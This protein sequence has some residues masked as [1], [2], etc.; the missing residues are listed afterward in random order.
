MARPERRHGEGGWRAPLL[1]PQAIPCPRARGEARGKGRRVGEGKEEPFTGHHRTDLTL[2]GLDSGDAPNPKPFWGIRA[3]G[4]GGPRYLPLLP[5]AGREGEGCE[6]GTPEVV[7]FG[8]RSLRA[9]RLKGTVPVRGLDLPAREGR[10]R[11]RRFRGRKLEQSV[12]RLPASGRRDARGRGQGGDPRRG[13][14]GSWPSPWRNASGRSGTL[15][16]DRGPWRATF[17]GRKAMY[18]H[19][20]RKQGR[21]RER[22]RRAERRRRPKVAPSRGRPEDDEAT[23]LPYG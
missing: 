5:F 8:R 1:G 2:F 20:S 10:E 7:G 4:P 13:E 14:G 21:E 19:P 16:R 3:L 18:T 22:R 6:R 12:G 9:D 15:L 23:L 17:R 11:R